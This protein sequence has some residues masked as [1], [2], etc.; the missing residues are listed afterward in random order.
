MMLEDCT[1]TNATVL[2]NC[3][4]SGTGVLLDLESKQLELRE[5]VYICWQ[6]LPG[7]FLIECATFEEYGWGATY[8]EALADLRS[9]IVELYFV[10]KKR[11]DRLG[12]P[13]WDLWKRYQEYTA[14]G[15]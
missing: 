8:G 2:E 11:L 6:Q 1:S 9:S 3:W 10:L 5:P 7:G 13:L 4:I 14:E 12:K 15:G